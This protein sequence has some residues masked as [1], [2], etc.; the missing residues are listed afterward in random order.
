LLPSG[1][2]CLDISKKAPWSLA[3]TAQDKAQRLFEYISKVYAI[4]LPVVRDFTK[5]G[6]E[7]WWQAD[8]IPS[9]QCRI[10][11]FDTG[12]N[13]AEAGS[14]GESIEEDAW[15]SVSKRSYDKPPPLEQVLTE[16]VELSLNP[17][18]RPTPKPSIFRRIH[19]EADQQRVSA[20]EEYVKAW[21][22]WEKTRESSPP[23][24]PEILV[25]WI[26]ETPGANLPPVLVE[27][28]EIEDR[29]EADPSRAQALNNYVEGQWSAWVKRVLPSFKANELYDQMFS[30]HQRLS[31]EGDRIEIVWGHVLLNWNHN[32]GAKVS[33]P[34]ILTPLNLEF[35]PERRTITLT[36]AHAHPSRF[37]VDCLGDLDYPHKDLLLHYVRNINNSESPPDAWSR[38]AMRGLASTV[39]GYLSQEAADDTN[40]YT[41]EPVARPPTSAKPTIY[42]ASTIFV[43]PR[44]R[45]LWIDDAKSVATSIATG[46]DIPPFIGSL[47]EDPKTTRLEIPEGHPHSVS[48]DEDDGESLLPLEYNDQ[49]RAIWDKLRTHF[50]VL[51]Q[52]PPGTGKSHTIANIVSALLARGQRVLVTSQTENAL[53]VLRDLIPEEIRNLCVS[54]LGNDTESKTQL[55]NAVVEIGSRLAEKN[56]PEPER[57]VQQIRRELRA[58][59][60]EQARL[61]HRIRDWAELDSCKITLG[62]EEISAHQAAKECSAGE[63][64]HA[65]FPDKL[66]PE[67]EPPLS[68]EELKGLC[69]LIREISPNDRR[70]CIQHLPDPEHIQSVE[71]ISTTF[72]ELRSASARSTETEAL[73][74]DWGD[75]LR[76]AQVADLERAISVVE[77]AL[78]DLQ[79]LSAEWQLRLLDRMASGENQMA[80]WKD[81]TRIC[82]ELRH[83]AWQ[84]FLKIHQSQIAIGN[85]PFDLDRETALDELERTLQKGKNPSGFITRL[86]LSKAAKL[87][88]DTVTVDGQKLTTPGR[89]ELIR[90]HFSYGA[91]VKKF[92]QIWSKSIKIVDGPRRDQLAPMPLADIDSRL[93]GVRNV[94]QWL[95]SHL[96]PIKTELLSLGCPASREDLHRASNLAKCLQTLHG[97]RAVIEEQSLM[98]RLREYEDA[99]RDES[100]KQGVHVLW[101]GFADAIQHRSPDEYERTYQELSRLIQLRPKVERLEHLLRELRNMAP[102]WADT[103]EREATESGPAA[104][105]EDWAFAWRWRRLHEWLT[106]LHNRD[107][108][109]SLQNSLEKARERE[110]GLLTRLVS[111]RTWQKQISKVKDHHYRALTAW[112]IVMKQFGKG[113]GKHAQRYLAAANKAMIEAV[114][115]VPVWIMPL[116]RVVQSFAAKPGIFDVVIVD[117]ASQCDIRALPV[118]YRAR[119]VVVVGDPE[120]ISPTNV[121]IPKDKVF[122][123]NRQFL[124]DIPFPERFD[125]DNSL[126]AIAG[127]IPTMD[128]ILLTEHF[129]CVPPIIEFNNRLCPSYGGNLEPLRQPHPQEMLDPPVRTVF[130]ENGFKNDSDINEPEAE[131]IVELLVRLCDDERYACGGKN[132]RKRTMGVISLLGE[133]QAKYISDLIARHPGLDERERAERRIICGDAYAFQGDERDVMFLSL[134]IAPNAPFAAQVTEA[135]RQRFNVATSRARDQVFLFH[136]VQLKDINNEECVRYKLLSWY[137]NPPKAEIEAGLEVL[138]QKA[139]TPFEIGVGEKI[140]TKG[141]IV[142]P[143]VRPFPKDF[144]YRIDLVIQGEKSRVAVECDG[145]QWHGPEQWEYDQRR[146]AQLR[147]A[148]WRFWRI[149]GSAFY[150]NKDRALEGLWCFLEDSG[151]RPRL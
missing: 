39:T 29:F 144:R 139:Q 37:D 76:T 73:R 111:E 48:I 122:E 44:L 130:I 79:G 51:V 117:E 62:R 83:R 149:S 84:S 107:G 67:I 65:W 77:P 45:R 11:L 85:L 13:I 9:A 82:T 105:P 95:D 94:V 131:A 124:G 132:N 32:L 20:F 12:N 138:R 128:R 148:G 53:K 113:T 150:R 74:A 30:L 4:D 136:S 121:G 140:I 43:R 93:N 58:V 10:K 8:L 143:Q 151:V 96:P 50:G 129:R 120:Q 87:L 133:K 64:K 103:I 72:S 110:R 36:P 71:Y 146:E 102:N 61:R 80:L 21:E 89:I 88:F 66:A 127:T 115:A 126:Y 134:V 119:N 75:Q 125:M 2:Y 47:I 137:L 22:D 86:A 56:S 135:A 92:E 69:I 15:L 5:Y 63:A 40:L 42:N 106:S 25:G 18:K 46:A 60:E 35:H 57:R 104:I 54:Q 112:A 3:V 1:R 59:R 114:G 6:A 90:A 33:H 55:N 23:P 91:D 100:R 78:S 28:R 68:S 145:D 147:R 26:D 19:F 52:G 17:T 99:L 38:N 108:V 14:Q 101:R 98:Q 16:W 70:S 97:Q 116:F 49:Q 31:V 41:D 7:P 118:L 27:E 123:L 81:F 24:S 109:E 141:Y 142:I 34:L